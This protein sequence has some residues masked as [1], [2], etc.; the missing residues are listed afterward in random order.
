MGKL[1]RMYAGRVLLVLVD[2]EDHEKHLREV[3]GV[4]FLGGVTVVLAWSNEEAGG[5]MPML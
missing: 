5:L 2:V 4:A 1:G 3:H